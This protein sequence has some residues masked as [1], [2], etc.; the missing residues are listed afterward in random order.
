M[1]SRQY[2]V[3]TD[4][5]GLERGLKLPLSAPGAIVR[6]SALHADSGLLLDAERMQVSVDGQTLSAGRQAGGLELLDGRDLQA[7]GMS[8]P[9]DSLAFQLPA[10]GQ[11]RSLNL[12][13]AGAPS[14]LP[15]VVHVFEPESEWRGTLSAPRHAFLTGNRLELSVGL[16]NGQERFAAQSVQTVLVSPDAKHA[17]P[18]EVTEDGFGLVGTTP[19]DLPAAGE[20][21]YEVHA[22]LSGRQGDVRI[23]RDLK[24]ALQVAAPTARLTDSLETTASNGLN[25]RLGVEVAAA[26][27][28]QVSGQVWGTDAEGNLQPLAMTQTA[29]LLEP[30]TGTLELEVPASLVMSSGLSAPFSVREVQLFDQGRMALIESRSRG[31]SIAREPGG[32]IRPYDSIEQ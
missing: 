20:G 32:P 17:W 13:M 29:A 2:W 11:P 12:Q 19:E 1:E 9:D 31:F 26:G 22:Y 28:Y 6:V 24:I 5:H 21:L 10:E 18:L 27:R 30:G 7:Q 23:Q 4:G 25:V 16:D 3:D 14:D 8:V 15:L